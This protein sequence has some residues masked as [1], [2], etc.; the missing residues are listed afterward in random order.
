MIAEV[1][2]RLPQ[3]DGRPVGGDG[4]LDIGSRE[5]LRNWNKQN[6]VDPGQRPGTT[7]EESAQLTALKMEN[8]EL[9]RANEI[10]KAAASSFASD[11][12]R[13][14]TLVTFIDEHRTASAASSRA[15]TQSLH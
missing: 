14:H 10:L 2:R 6:E 7:S 15:K 8:A 1:P 11:L 5:T 13:P 3:Q 9:E 12:D 4:K